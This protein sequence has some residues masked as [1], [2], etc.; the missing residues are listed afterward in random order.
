MTGLLSE[1]QCKA[2][3]ARR[4]SKQKPGIKKEVASPD[5]NEGVDTALSAVT[6]VHTPLS[7][8]NPSASSFAGDSSEDNP[9]MLMPAHHRE[10]LNT[11]MILQEKFEFPD[12]ENVKVASVKLILFCFAVVVVVFF[13]FVWGIVCCCFVCLFLV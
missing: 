7:L 11:L 6:D 8:S 9:L 10:T 3:D 5:S 12:E 1:D 4:K 2:R 13:C